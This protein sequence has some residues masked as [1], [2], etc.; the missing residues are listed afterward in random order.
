[1]ERTALASVIVLFFLFGSSHAEIQVCNDVQ[2]Q[3]ATC[4]N[5]N[6]TFCTK[7]VQ[8]TSCAPNGTWAAI[9]DADI[10][11]TVRNFPQNCSAQMAKF[12]CQMTFEQ[13]VTPTQYLP[14]CYNYCICSF[15]LC[16]MAKSDVVARCNVH[17]AELQ[18]AP[19]VGLVFRVRC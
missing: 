16:G 18:V 4:S 11:T 8:Y 12:F 14:L 19:E 1:M 15:T 13:C 2:S 10:G 6:I 7:F 5:P 9:M 3:P 17:V